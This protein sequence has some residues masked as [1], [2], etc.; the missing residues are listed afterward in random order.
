MDKVQRLILS[1]L[2]SLMGGFPLTSTLCLRLFNL[3][4]GSD[5]ASVARDAITSMMKLPQISFA[6]DIGQHQLLHHLRF[7]IDYLR[8]AHLLDGVG[9]PQNLFA[10]AAHLYYT[11]PSNFAL[12]T[13]FR[14][15]VIHKLCSQQSDTSA[16]QELVLLLS[17]IFG[18]RYLTASYASKRSIQALRQR[19]PS[20]V[21]LPPLPDHARKVLVEH[22]RETLRVFTAY[23]LAYVSQYS[24]K[25][26]VDDRLPLSKQSYEGSSIHDGS[27]F[28]LHLE[29][30]AI[31]VKARSPFVANS[32]HGDDFHSVQELART[33]RQGLYLNEHAI[34]SLEH[35]VTGHDERS[36]G[37]ALNAYLLD[38]YIHGQVGTLAAANGIRRGDVWYLLENFNLTLKTIRAAWYQ[39]LLKASKEEKEEKEAG[40]DDSEGAE[41]MDFDEGGSEYEEEGEASEF[42]RPL[43]VREVNW[44]VFQIINE[45]A[46]EFEGKFKAMWA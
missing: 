26:G 29:K 46:D 9:K 30:S 13:L 5:H 25:L 8:R 33:A 7:S 21:L 3:L 28:R 20:K 22:D 39:L 38:F 41:E 6:S 45:V 40:D 16:K 14:Q 32:G 24:A 4:E 18:R 34:P 36:G 37:H 43:G 11:E 10:M 42:K 44:K 31:R 35:I 1:N 17:H 12:I 19:Y 2:P 23:A 15:G 27:L